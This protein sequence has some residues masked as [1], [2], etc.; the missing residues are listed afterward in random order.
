VAAGVVMQRCGGGG[1]DGMTGV[2]YGRRNGN[3]PG[4]NT[5]CEEKFSRG[6]N[7]HVEMEWG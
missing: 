5:S 2:K 1:G 7:A 3:T 6:K 4:V